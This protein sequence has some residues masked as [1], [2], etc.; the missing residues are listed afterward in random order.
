MTKASKTD[1]LVEGLDTADGPPTRP[2]EA[3]MV[4]VVAVKRLFRVVENRYVEAGQE[5]AVEP[6][7]AT[8][9]LGMGLVRR[10]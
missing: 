5:V 4:T 2:A 1:E 8:K 10:A 7:T 9:L 6:A 3:E